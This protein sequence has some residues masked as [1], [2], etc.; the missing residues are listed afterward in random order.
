MQ[1]KIDTHFAFELESGA[2]ALL[3]FEVATTPAQDILSEYT[4]LTVGHDSYRIA[5]QDGIGDRLWVGGDG[6]I[7]V[8]YT[9]DVA[10]SRQTPDLASLSAAPMRRLPA[11][12]VQYL[13]D[14]HYCPADQ[15]QSFVI[16][17]FG[18]SVGG[19]RIESIRRWIADNFTYQPG[20]SDARTDARSSFIE[21]RGICRDYAHVLVTLARAS[22][23]PARYVAGY[24][25][26]VTPP[27]FHAVAEVF[28]EDP[29]SA[30]EGTWHVVDAT[31]MASGGDFAKIGVGRDAADVSFLSAFGPCEFLRSTVEV[32][33]ASQ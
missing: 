26:Q 27:D 31:G 8:N 12:A 32:K 7:E 28:L 4:T 2:D 18:K 3:Q 14:S 6:L 21:R 5:A 20:I 1:I 15:F 19:Q 17:E 23:I 22:G 25:P 30:S 9:A 24:A 33:T 29:N 13:F 16:A 11:Q 10:I